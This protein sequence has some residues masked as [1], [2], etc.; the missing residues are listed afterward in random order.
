MREALARHVPPT[1]PA[2]TW[3]LCDAIRS[4]ATKLLPD[5]VPL[6]P[7]YERWA[8]DPALSAQ[9]R[10]SVESAVKTLRQAAG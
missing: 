4:M 2:A 10:R 6:L 5:F 1:D 7:L 9:E 3:V 8:A